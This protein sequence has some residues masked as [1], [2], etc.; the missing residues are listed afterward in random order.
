MKIPLDIPRQPLPD[1]GDILVADPFMRDE[2]LRRTV[3]YLCEVSD[4]GAYGMVLNHP[5]PLPM[6]L[7]IEGFPEC[8]FKTSYGGPVDDE[9]LFYIHNQDDIDNSEEISKDLF[10]GGSFDEI[11][12]RIITGELTLSD[13]RFFIGYTGWDKGQLQQEVKDK[14]WIVWKTHKRT[15]L[16]SNDSELWSTCMKEMG[17]IYAE[18]E[19]Y[20]LFYEHN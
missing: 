4:D 17:G 14:S 7:V 18:M 5:L 6:N 1:V 19:K 11:K 8:E 10:F 15:I 13:L 3:I 16:N 9:K 12:T 2:N 20:P